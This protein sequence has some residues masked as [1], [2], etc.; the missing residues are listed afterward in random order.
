MAATPRMHITDATAAAIDAS[1]NAPLRRRRRGAAATKEDTSTLEYH[2]LPDY[3]KDNEFIQKYYRSPNMPFKKTLLSLFGIHNETGN[4]WTHL[5]G[6][7]FRAAADVC[8]RVR[9]IYS[10]FQ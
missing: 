2:E 6:K 5:L 1:R 4:V 7:G 9:S 3:L 10:V 8:S